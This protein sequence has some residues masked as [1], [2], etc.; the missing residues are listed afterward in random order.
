M[1]YRGEKCD[2]RYTHIDVSFDDESVI[3][4]SLLVHY[5]K[6]E[7]KAA[8]IQM[9][10]MK[11]ITFDQKSFSL[12]T[13]LEFNMVFIEMLNQYYLLVLREKP[14]VLAKIS[15]QISSSYRCASVSDTDDKICPI[16]AMCICPDCYYGSR[17]QFSTKGLTLSLDAILGYQIYPNSNIGIT[18]QPLVIKTAMAITITLFSLS[19][20]NSFLSIL[21]FRMQ[22]TRDV[23]CGLYLYVSSILSILIFVGLIIKFTFL[24]L[25]QMKLT[26]Q[27]WLVEIQYIIMDY[28]LRI[29]LSSIDWLHACVAIERTM[30][31][32]K[33]IH[34][35]KK[36]S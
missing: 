35:N 6:V 7:N 1:H 3:P 36:K 5:I 21:T 25:S 12:F 30:N 20:I 17:C 11:K 2:I 26:H 4:Q 32:F 8:P 31:V 16:T 10:F 29:L 24:I 34:F 28:L 14:I 9:S 13:P 22:A 33:G 19:S 15:A 23:G 27:R 18:Q